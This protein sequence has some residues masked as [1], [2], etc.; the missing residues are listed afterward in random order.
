MDIRENLF[1]G[2]GRFVTPKINFKDMVKDL[3]QQRPKIDKMIKDIY[4]A[5]KLTHEFLYTEFTI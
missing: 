3:M 4:Y 5:E 1:D 2:D